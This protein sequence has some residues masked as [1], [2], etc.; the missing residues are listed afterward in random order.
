MQAFIEMFINKFGYLSVA[1]LIA[2]ENIF[3]PI[4][5]EV[6][7]L[8]GGFATTKSNLNVVLVILFA[9]IGSVFGAIV[10]YLL[11]RILTPARMEFLINKYGKFLRLKMEDIEKA[12]KWF[13]TK[14]SLTVFFCRFIPIIRS[15]ISIPAG[16]SKMSLPK[17]FFYTTVGTA[18]WNTVL[19]YLGA[20]TGENWH[21]IEAIFDK[22]SK[23]FY[24]LIA[25][26]GI[27]F[28]VWFFW[29]RHRKTKIV[30]FKKSKNTKD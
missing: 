8:Y 6:I 9:T 18:I 4:P 28:L 13:N 2:V 7:L 30:I 20:I 25:V 23:V 10:L 29:L 24:V 1:L 21:S 12:E 27:A 17:F 19:V 16:I 22:Y 5:S 11:G 3:P 14:G 15:L 26:A